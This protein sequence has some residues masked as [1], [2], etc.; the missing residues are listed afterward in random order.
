M[1]YSYDRRPRT[2]SEGF[3]V[4]EAFL[5]QVA[6]VFNHKYAKTRFISGTP[7]VTTSDSHG[8]MY[9]RAQL[10]PYNDSHVDALYIWIWKDGRA[11][12]TVSGST[13]G[14]DVES[15]GFQHA[16]AEDN[17]KYTK[18]TADQLAKMAFDLS[19]KM[20]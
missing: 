2:A 4:D 5:E 15:Q 9:L 3:P 20:D 8:I 11:R 18:Q 16:H 13:P 1:S 12:M 6:R 7:E 19:K 10:Q 17:F 14:D